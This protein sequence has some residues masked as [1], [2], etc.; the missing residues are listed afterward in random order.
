MPSTSFETAIGIC[1]LEW[2]EG[3]DH[4]VDLPGRRRSRDRRDGD[5]PA[6]RRRGRSRRSR[7]CWP[8]TRSTCATVPVDLGRASEFDRSV[9]AVAREVGPGETITYGEIADRDRAAGRRARGR[10][11]ARAQPGADRRPLPPG[12]RGRWGAGR[13]LRARRREDE[14]EDAR[15]RGAARTGNAVRTSRPA[16]GRRH[17]APGWRRRR[18]PVAARVYV[19]ELARPRPGRAATR[20]SRGS[21]SARA[22]ATPSFGSPSTCAATSR[23]GSSSV[24]G[25]R[26]R[27]DLYDDLPAYRSAREACDAEAERARELAACGFVAHCDGTSHG[28]GEGGWEE[29]DEDRLAAV[30][31]PRRRRGDRALRVVVQRP[32]RRSLRA[33]PSRRAR[34]LGRRAPRSRRPATRL[35]PLRPRRASTRSHV[36]PASGYRAAPGALAEL[37]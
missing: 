33:P 19:I 9:Y 18:T 21:T 37:P 1:S 32:R 17:E 24:H 10:R 13:L 8:A 6:A 14:A 7:R 28:S 16:D 30:C 15:D 31:L 34:L 12:R 26:L 11:G 25:L 5:P 29:W 22:P 35:R 2:S 23:P 36:A 27:P 20:G 3:A 4:P